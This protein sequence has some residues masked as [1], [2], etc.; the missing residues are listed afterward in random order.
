MA[1]RH[2]VPHWQKCVVMSLHSVCLINCCNSGNHP[3]I[4]LCGFSITNGMCLAI[5]RF[6]KFNTTRITRFAASA[7][8]LS[9]CFYDGKKPKDAR[10]TVVALESRYLHRHGHG[11]RAR[12]W[13]TAAPT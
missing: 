11:G 4:L 1:L 13:Y 7:L 12:R 6:K 10:L 3:L 9:F 8:A 5:S 2:P